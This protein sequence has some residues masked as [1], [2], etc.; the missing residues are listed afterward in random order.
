MSAT[1]AG[2]RA[3]GRLAELHDEIEE[4][5]TERRV[6]IIAAAGQGCRLT[7]IAAATGLSASMVRR[8]AVGSR[9]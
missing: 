9:R 6:L 4:R 3:L 1:A 2:I 7:D 8:I 5:T